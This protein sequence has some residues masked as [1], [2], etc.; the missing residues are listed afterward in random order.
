MR[1]VKLSVCVQGRCA[2]NLCRCVFRL[3]QCVGA[4]E[5]LHHRGGREGNRK[6]SKK[7][8]NNNS[9]IFV[10]YGSEIEFVHQP[11]HLHVTVGHVI[12]AVSISHP[13]ENP[14]PPSDPR[15]AETEPLNC[16]FQLQS[17]LI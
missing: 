12:P 6:P 1:L 8:K 7:D 15:T 10:V 17:H 2:S 14:T 16:L 13:A 5:M 11:V 3:L 9:T 4:A